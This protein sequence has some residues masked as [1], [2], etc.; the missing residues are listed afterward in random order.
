MGE[1][2]GEREM[3]T[4]GVKKDGSEEKRTIRSKCTDSQ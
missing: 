4:D 3:K 2:K 1:M